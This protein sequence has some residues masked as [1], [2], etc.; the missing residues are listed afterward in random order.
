M[1]KKR[2]LLFALLSSR[3]PNCH[4]GKIFTSSNPYN[5]KVLASMPE[6]CPVCKLDFKPETGF[7]WGALYIS[8]GLSV[9]LS[10]ALFIAMYLLWGWLVWQFILTDAV[11]LIFLAPVLLRFSRVLWMYLWF[12]LFPGSWKN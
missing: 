10:I 11:L 2:N 5:L 6:Q 8:Y 7:Y 12:K 4:E 1:T 9:M 3:C